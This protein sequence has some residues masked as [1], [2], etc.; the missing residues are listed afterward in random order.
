MLHTP[1]LRNRTT[2][3][4]AG[5]VIGLLALAGTAAASSHLIDL[6]T[7]NVQGG[8]YWGIET[9]APGDAA[10]NGLTYARVT[11]KTCDSTASS[12][13]VFETY[14]EPTNSGD[15]N[16]EGQLTPVTPAADR[17]AAQLA[18]QGAYEGQVYLE[19]SASGTRV[20]SYL[21]NMPEGRLF[22]LCLGT[23]DS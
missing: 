22:R 8:G 2:R 16:W 23:P 18:A 20:T 4:I 10:A 12:A 5:A 13:L 3:A 7:A 11:D 21:Y 1:G 19:P 14:L 9:F 17:L 6:G 15:G